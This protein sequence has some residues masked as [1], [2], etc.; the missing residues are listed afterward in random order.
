MGKGA[1][2]GAAT[3][4]VTVATGGAGAVAGGAL[5]ATGA[6]DRVLD[7]YRKQKENCRSPRA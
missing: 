1:A 7:L 5:A 3:V 6:T 4:V 2:L